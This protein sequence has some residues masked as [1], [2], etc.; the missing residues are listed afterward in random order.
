MLHK[1]MIVVATT[2]VVGGSALSTSA[3]ARDGS[4]RPYP[5]PDGFRGNHFAG[6]FKRGRTVGGSHTGYVRGLRG[7][8]NGDRQGDV[9]GHWGEYY[10][11]MVSVP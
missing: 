5:G 3:F 8:L 11:P 9:W 10:G 2:L 7:G 4:Y 6:A 1:T